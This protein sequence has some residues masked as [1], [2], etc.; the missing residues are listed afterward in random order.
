MRAEYEDIYR[1]KS[2]LWKLRFEELKCKKSPPWTI[3]NLNKAIKGLKNNQSGDPNGIISELFKP[4]VL[5]QDLAQG[6]FMLCN[7]MK[8]EQFIPALVQLANIT[9][10]FE[11]QRQQT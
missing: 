6:L 5:G 11:E 1:L 4:G 10:I 9:T 8:S 3:G 7:G 2:V